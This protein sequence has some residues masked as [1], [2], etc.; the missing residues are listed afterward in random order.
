M[1]KDDP[2]PDPITGLLVGDIVMV[3]KATFVDHGHPAST[4]SYSVFASLVAMKYT[5]KKIPTV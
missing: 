4:L 1:S 2:S 3:I 5:V